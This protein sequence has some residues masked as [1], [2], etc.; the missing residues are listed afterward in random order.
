MLA[1]LLLLLAPA[2]AGLTALLIR[3]NALR[4]WTLPVLALVH[5]GGTLL[6]LCGCGATPAGRDNALTTSL[7]LRLD[8]T[9]AV[10][11]LVVSVLFLLVAVYAPGYLRTQPA[12]SN[13]A[14][15]VC[16]CAFLGLASLATLSQHLGLMWAA[17]EGATLTCA[18]MIYFNRSSRSL[19][20]TWKYLMVGGVGIALALLGTFFLA[21]AAIAAGHPCELTADA[22]M[23]SGGL[24]SPWVRVAFV[25]LLVGYGTKMGLAPLHAWKPDAYG[26]SPGIVGALLAGGMTSVAF[27]AL[28]RVVGVV[29]ASGGASLADGSLMTLGLISMAWASVFM[30]RQTDIKRMLAYSSVEHMGILAV[31]LA[32][33]PAAL[34]A[35]LLHL[36][37]N[38]WA[39]GALFIAAGNIHRAF[40]SKHIP[41]VSG[42]MLRLPVSGGGFLLGFLAATGTPPFSLFLSELGLLQVAAASGR[43]WLVG[44][45]LLCLIVIFAGFSGTV[46]TAVLGDS[47][48]P[49]PELA[50]RDSWWTTASPVAALVLV[51]GLGLWIP[52]PLRALFEAA[53]NDLRW[54]GDSP[55]LV[56]STE[57]V[58]P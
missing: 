47:R 10:V 43:W 23:A 38:A 54:R 57:E 52:A 2:V 44:V 37:G 25:L 33:G 20:A 18:P 48:A 39:K 21:Y 19:E 41:E 28:S 17:V 34:P 29:R 1:P 9:G 32:L 56:V 11:L 27:L 55:R 22:L 53:A 3:S 5:L 49:E 40:S 35:V 31:G 7:W 13:K 8:G 50:H 24:S 36:M 42:A 4:P 45:F 26:E 14:L 6:A 15:V 51:L 46:L 16:C 58:Q 12:R 30:V